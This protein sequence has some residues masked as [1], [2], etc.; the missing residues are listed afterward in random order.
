MLET[1]LSEDVFR[2]LD[3][4][5]RQY[6]DYAKNVGYDI[7]SESLRENREVWANLPDMVAGLLARKYGG[8]CPTKYS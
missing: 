6:I 4:W 2:T 7:T 3:N 5:L 8:L 1:A